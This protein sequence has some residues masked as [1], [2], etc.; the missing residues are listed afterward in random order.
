MAIEH[1]YLSAARFPRLRG[2]LARHG[3]LYE[4]LDVEYGVRPARATETIETALAD[5]AGGRAARGGHR[6]ADAAALPAQPGRRR[7]P[8]EWVRSVYRGDRYKFVAHLSR[9]GRRR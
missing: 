8:V 4:A 6:P 7:T 1:T 9:P 5:P 2:H 3:S